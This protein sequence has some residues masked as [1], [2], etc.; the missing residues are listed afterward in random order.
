TPAGIS[1][2]GYN[3]GLRQFTNGAK[4]C[5]HFLRRVDDIARQAR[6]RY[7]I[8]SRGS[9]DALSKKALYYFPW[10]H[11]FHIEADHAR[12]K[13]FIARR[14]QL[15]AGHAR[16]SL[17]HLRVELV[18]PRGDSRRAYVLVKPNRLQERPTMFERVE[19]AG[20]KQSRSRRSR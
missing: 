9:D 1:D 13:I 4:H 16:K 10:F 3:I 20:G 5:L 7:A 12:G 2:A 19:T 6:I 11:P 18:C 17:F 14:V 15:D 8:R